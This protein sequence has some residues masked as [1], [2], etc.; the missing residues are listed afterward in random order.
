MKYLIPLLQGGK[1][2][3]SAVK[4]SKFYLVVTPAAIETENLHRALRV[5][6]ATLKKSFTAVKGG[7]ASF[8]ADGD[9]PAFNAFS[10]INDTF[11]QIEDAISA[12]MAALN[13]EEKPLSSHS[14]QAPVS[15]ARS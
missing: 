11:K 1:Q 10:S 3:G 13:G 8:R 12:A 15:T 7:E 2:A 6:Q 5:F 14:Q 9:G 4:F